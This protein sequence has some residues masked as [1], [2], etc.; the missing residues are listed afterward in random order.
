MII[1]TFSSISKKNVLFCLIITPLYYTPVSLPD[2]YIYTSTLLQSSP[3]LP[4]FPTH[5]N[6]FSIFTPTL[7]HFFI[8]IFFSSL[9]L[10]SPHPSPLHSLLPPLSPSSTLFFSFLIL[11]FLT[12]SFFTSL[13]FPLYS[14]QGSRGGRG[15]NRSNYDNRRSGGS[16]G[17]VWMSG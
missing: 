17:G 12:P 11:F 16:V 15:S 2:S 13:P 10:Y 1:N 14:R 9:S 8:S 3:S 6:P 5:L 7:S 4:P